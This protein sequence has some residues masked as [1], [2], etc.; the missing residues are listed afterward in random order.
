MQIKIF[1]I[2]IIDSEQMEVSLNAF[3]R[4]HKV[5]QV[6]RQAINTGQ[7][8]YWSFCITYI[9]GSKERSSDKRNEKSP[10]EK[11]DYKKLLNEGD[12]GRFSAF[13]AI[14]KQL[15]D[16]DAVPAYAVFT[17]AEVVEIAKLGEKATLAEI[18]KIPGIGIKKI[19]KY[20]HHFISGGETTE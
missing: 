15:A 2:P 4:S 13:R 12:F 8:A 14:R 16:A 10:K 11:P 1:T 3:L 5:L 19:E 17:N 9:E 6:E 20:G 7:G 18:R